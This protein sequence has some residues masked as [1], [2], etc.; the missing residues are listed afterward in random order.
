MR[1]GFRENHH[2]AHRLIE[3]VHGVD[4]AAELPRKKRRKVG[5]SFSLRTH[6]DGLHA[7]RELLCPPYDF[8]H[9]TA[10]FPAVFYHNFRPAR[11]RA[12]QER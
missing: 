2:A 10:A 7:E 6:A 1:S 4:F 8:K 9:P 11:N 12:G 3:P 5:F